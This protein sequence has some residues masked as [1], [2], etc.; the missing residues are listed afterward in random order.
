MLAG[1]SAPFV[2][3]PEVAEDAGQDSPFVLPDAAPEAAP[4]CAQNDPSTCVGTSV[5]EC[6]AGAWS[7]DQCPYACQ[8][9]TCTG[10]CVPGSG[11]IDCNGNH[12]CDDTGNWSPITAACPADGG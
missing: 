10:L 9:G 11:M 12:T 5:R 2:G 1:C 8:F 3:A 6:V 7:V 4:E